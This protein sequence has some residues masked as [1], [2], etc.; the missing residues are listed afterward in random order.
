MNEKPSYVCGRCVNRRAHARTHAALASARATVYVTPAAVL[1]VAGSFPGADA[2]GCEGCTQ[3]AFMVP[4]LAVGLL[5]LCCL[6]VCWYCRRG[7]VQV[8]HSM[9]I[10]DG[11]ADEIEGDFQGEFSLVHRMQGGTGSTDSPAQVDGDKM[12]YQVRFRYTQGLDGPS[13]HN[14][15][16]LASDATGAQLKDLLTSTNGRAFRWTRLRIDEEELRPGDQLEGR[17]TNSERTVYIDVEWE[18]YQDSDESDV[19]Q[20]PAQ[21]PRTDTDDAEYKCT[22]HPP[23]KFVS[24]TSNLHTIHPLRPRNGEFAPVWHG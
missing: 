1:L 22:N 9:D 5:L 24:P 21:R 10:E 16:D 23:G 20:P 18:R 14:V 8:E 6:C 4:A 15:L 2:A 3:G 19:D 17:V 7:G 13:F 12:H 11:L